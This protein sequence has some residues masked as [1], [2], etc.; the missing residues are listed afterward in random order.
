MIFIRQLAYWL[1]IQL[2][3]KLL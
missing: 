3:N 1:F 2:R